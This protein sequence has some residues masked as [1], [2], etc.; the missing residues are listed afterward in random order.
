MIHAELSDD[1]D[2]HVGCKRV[3]RLMR[4]D[5]LRGATLR[6]YI[7]TTV[8]DTSAAQPPDLVQRRF[9]AEEPNRL[10]VADFSVPQ[11]AA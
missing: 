4:A 5:G 1:Y 6:R 11:Q 7:V 8:S 10:W 9:Y 3:A 2:I